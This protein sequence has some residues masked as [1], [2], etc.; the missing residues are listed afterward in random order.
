[1]EAKFWIG[2]EA[3]EIKEAFKYIFSPRDTREVK[4]IIYQHLE[5]IIEQWNN[6]Q[7]KS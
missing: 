3:F 2:N 4:K 1:M 5:H 6:F 7:N